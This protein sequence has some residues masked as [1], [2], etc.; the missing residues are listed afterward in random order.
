MSD[1]GSVGSGSSGSGS[2]GG[3]SSSSSSSSSGDSGD[4]TTAAGSSDVSSKSAE[5]ITMGADDFLPVFIYCLVQA[6]WST[7]CST[8]LLL[9][10][11]ADPLKSNDEL[12]YYMVSIAC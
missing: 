11:L 3:S 12:Q 9:R 1:G 6:H 8:L 5:T 7:P 10:L 2:S 4:G